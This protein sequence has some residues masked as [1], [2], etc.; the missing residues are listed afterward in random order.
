MHLVGLA[1]EIAEE[2]THAVPLLVP[3]ASPVRV[4]IDHPVALGLA[5]LGPGGIARDACLAGVFQQIA[6]AIGP[7]RCLQRLDHAVAQCLAGVGDH[8][9]H[10]DAD[11]PAEATT[12][13]A[14]AESRV[15]RKQRGLRVGVAQVAVG[16]VQTGGVAPE[17][18]FGALIQAVDIDAAAAALDRQ[19]DRLDH[20]DLVGAGQPEPVG[21][22]IEHF[23]VIDHALGLDPGET[24]GRQPLLDLGRCHGLGQLDRKGDHQPRVALRR[25]ACHQAGVDR[26]GRVVSH[27]LRGLLVEQLR[28]SGK[29]QFQVVVQLGH[30]ADRGARSAHRI[31]LVDRDRRR[32]AVDPIDRRPIHAVEKLPRVGRK[33]LDIAPLALGVKCVEHQA[34]LARTARACDHRHLAGADVEVEVL[35]V[36]LARAAYADQPGRVARLIRRGGLTVGGWGQLGSARHRAHSWGQGPTFEGGSCRQHGCG[37]IGRPTEPVVRNGSASASASS[38]TPTR[39]SSAPTG[40]AERAQSA[41]HAGGKVVDRQHEQQ[42]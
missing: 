42:A 17:I 40:G 18:R 29:Q 9:P 24:A 37:A 2:A 10:V 12:G 13:L 5:E 35:Q 14:G 11:H 39:R 27:R 28:G 1:L 19:L 31:G 26:L 20:P 38:T 21:H 8:Q 34:G 16:T 30:R 25:S 7:G 6:L 22:H 33:G 41:H 36:V 23:P 32:H 15:E 4:A 3:V